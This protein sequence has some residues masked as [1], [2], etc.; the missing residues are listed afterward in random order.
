MSREDFEALVEDA[1]EEIPDELWDLVDN[2]AIIVE[3][4]PPPDQPGDLL[5]L[6]DGV[7]LTERGDYA[8][9]LPDRV[10]IFREP[11]LAICQD[12]EEVAEE[13]CITVIHEIAHFFGIEDDQLHEWGWG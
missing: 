4:A 6:Y 3:D 13:V 7:P 1:L 10:F 11:T 5:G 2:V 12:E 9:F 8:G